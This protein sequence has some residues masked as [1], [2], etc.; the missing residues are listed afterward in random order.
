MT[1]LNSN[2]III[3]NAVTIFKKAIDDYNIEMIEKLLEIGIDI[4]IILEK[5]YDDERNAIIYELMKGYRNHRCDLVNLLIEKGIELKNNEKKFDTLML[6]SSIGCNT[7]L[8]KMLDK[9]LNIDTKTDDGRTT[10]Y[11]AIINKNED[12]VNLLL[13]NGADYEYKIYGKTILEYAIEKK[14][15]QT[16]IEKLEIK[17]EKRKALEEAKIEGLIHSIK[18]KMDRTLRDW[19]KEKDNYHDKKRFLEK[20]YLKI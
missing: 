18:K 13:E 3:E 16:I 10:L 4:N 17:S 14:L 11:E 2:K 5:T 20:Y 6:S 1:N 9:Q 12:T 8:K 19:V 15:N 7:C